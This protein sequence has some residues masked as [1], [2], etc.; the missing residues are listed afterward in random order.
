MVTETTGRDDVEVLEGDEGEPEV[1]R[2][3]DVG[4]QI[5]LTRLSE[6]IHKGPPVTLPADA[7]VAKAVDAMKR[8]RVSA[9]MVVDTKKPKKLLGI[10]TERDVVKKVLDVKG[11]AK[12]T[13]RKAM[14]K[15]PES[16]SAKDSVAFALNKMSVGGYRH[17]PVVDDRDVPT[18]MVSTRD[19]IDFIVELCPE[20]LL[21]LPSQPELAVHRTQEGD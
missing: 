1:G 18:G 17:V 10:F 13:L 6:V 7:T 20:E 12:L 14:T 21:N 2:G 16:L 19:L 3:R 9:V 11:F 15:N 5:L 4:R 8:K